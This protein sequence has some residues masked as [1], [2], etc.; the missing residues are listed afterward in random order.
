MVYD[1]LNKLNCRFNAQSFQ[2]QGIGQF[3]PCVWKGNELNLIVFNRYRASTPE[4]HSALGVLRTLVM[5]GFTKWHQLVTRAV[6][7]QQWNWHK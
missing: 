1:A 4:R 7:A 6:K 2:E 5:D 3:M